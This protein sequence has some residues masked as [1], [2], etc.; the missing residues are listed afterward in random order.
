MIEIKFG[1]G[2]EAFDDYSKAINYVLLQVQNLANRV[3][4]GKLHLPVIM[5]LMDVN[6]NTVGKM[7]FSK[8]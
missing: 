2:N 6:G 1:T 7:K 5:K 4:D 3:G 8:R